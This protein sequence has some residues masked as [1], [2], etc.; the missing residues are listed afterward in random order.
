[1]KKLSTY[2]FLSILTLALA[3]A[4][5]A[6][7]L[8][9]EEIEQRN[10]EIIR[11]SHKDLAAGD[12]EAFKSIGPVASDPEDHCEPTDILKHLTSDYLKINLLPD[13]G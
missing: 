7:D 12:L 1:M 6:G 8:S 10:M 4:G 2:F 5:Q 13:S 11:Q 9:T 3:V